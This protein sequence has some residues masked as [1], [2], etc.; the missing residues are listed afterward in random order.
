MTER[1]KLIKEKFE[2]EIWLSQHDYIGIKIA[3]GRASISEYAD[4]IAEMTVKANRLN[5]INELLK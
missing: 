4:V 3:T 1:E 2:L 5:E